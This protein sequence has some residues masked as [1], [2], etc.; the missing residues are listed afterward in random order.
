MQLTVC[1]PQDLERLLPDALAGRVV[2][3]PVDPNEPSPVMRMLQPDREVTEPDAALVVA[4]AGSTGDPKGV[5]L[6]RHALIAAARNAEEVTGPLA[7]TLALPAFYVAGVMVLVRAAVAGTPLTRVRS[8]LGDLPTATRPSGVSI[9][10]TQLHRAL[11]DPQLLARLATYERVLVGGAPVSRADVKAAKAAGVRVTSTYGMSETCGG[12]VWNG[13]ALPGVEV[14][15][16]DAGRVELGGDMVFSGYR[17][18]PDL[19]AEVLHGNRV[20]TNDRGRLLAGHLQVTG[21]LDDVVISGGVNV[22][23]AAVERAV[24]NFTDA[25]AAVVGVED[26]EWGTR[27]V[28]ATTDPHDLAAWRARLRSVLE[29]PALPRQVLRMD[30]LPRLA[31]G[32]IDRQALRR[33]IHAGDLPRRGRPGRADQA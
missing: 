13:L 26:P 9:V 3:A 12:C 15:I 18:R 27:V 17:L 7:W 23:L 22:D 25:E 11:R 20:L 29:A 10:P 32:K 2:L 21:R 4:T 8:D 1:S 14:R 6:S 5:V 30:E 28:L 24:T 16:G 33:R 31:S 19:T